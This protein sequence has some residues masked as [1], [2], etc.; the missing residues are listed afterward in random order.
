VF[1]LIFHL[2]ELLHGQKQFLFLPAYE[3]LLSDGFMQY[4]QIVFR[5]AAMN[6]IRWRTRDFKDSAQKNYD[7]LRDR[8]EFLNDYWLGN[9]EYHDVHIVGGRYVWTFAVLTGEVI[10]EQFDEYTDEWYN[11]ENGERVDLK[12]PIYEDISIWHND[13]EAYLLLM[14]NLKLDDIV[15]IINQSSSKTDEKVSIIMILPSIALVSTLFVCCIVN[16]VR[17]YGIHT[18]KKER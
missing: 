12:Q 3:E 11:H 14:D 10:P 18:R 7:F 9:G 17:V 6:Q 15:S 8:I 4:E 16:F 1:Q 13:A 2:S 5:A